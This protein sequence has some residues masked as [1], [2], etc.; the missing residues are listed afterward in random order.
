MTTAELA[1]A[2]TAMLKAD[3]HKEAA[4]RFNAPDMVS[5]EAMEGPMAVCSGTAEVKAKSDWWYANHEVHS[6]ETSEPLVNGNQFLL[7]FVIDVTQLYAN[8]RV[9]AEEYGL[10]TVQDGKIIE[11]RFFYPPA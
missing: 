6:F 5:R 2:F 8:K 7:R 1:Q 10:Y 4:A 11:E 3:Q 9:K